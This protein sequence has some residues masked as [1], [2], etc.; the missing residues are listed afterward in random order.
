MESSGVFSNRDE[1]L[2]VFELCKAV[3]DEITA[4]EIRDFFRS[5]KQGD[6]FIA[7]I[8]FLPESFRQSYMRFIQGK[9]SQGSKANDFLNNIRK[10]LDRLQK[11]LDELDPGVSLP[12]IATFSTKAEW[13]CVAPGCPEG[14]EFKLEQLI[15]PRFCGT[16]V[17][18]RKCAWHSKCLQAI[19]QSGD[20]FPL[21]DC[22]CTR[23]EIN[24]RKRS[25]VGFLQGEDGSAL[26][27]LKAE[28]S[29]KRNAPDSNE[30]GSASKRPKPDISLK[31]NGFDSDEADEHESKRSRSSSH[32]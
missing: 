28:I 26:K 21:L 3:R 9:S 5:T 18:S 13:R 1:L 17:F 29:L 19:A 2:Q 22:S 11:G 12:R 4:K 32:S 20:M 10:S 25:A 24:E 7:A 31:R 6:H 23:G 27:R 14:G 16:K 15:I 8:A 30:A